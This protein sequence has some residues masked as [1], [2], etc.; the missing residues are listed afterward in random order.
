M[1]KKMITSLTATVLVGFAAVPAHAQAPADL[2]YRVGPCATNATVSDGNILGD[3][4]GVSVE[5]ACPN[6]G[7]D[8]APARGPAMS[9]DE[10]SEVIW[11]SCGRDD[12]PQDPAGA[13]EGAQAAGQAAAASACYLVRMYG[14][15][16]SGG[17]S[18]QVAAARAVANLEITAP[19]IGLTGYGKPESMEL[20]GL[21]TWMW[22]ADP[23]TSTTGPVTSTGTDGGAT[24]TATGTVRK[25]VWDMG[26]GGTVTCSGA[27]AA[28]T[29]YD[30]AYGTDPSPT[31]GY[32]YDRTSAGQPGDAFTVTVTVYWDV[33]WSGEGQS[34]TLATS[35]TR[36]TQLRVGE[37]QVII[38]ERGPGKK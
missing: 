15:S 5:T 7:G 19:E 8:A 27:S 32:R 12:I 10:L 38:D 3:R 16:G 37:V 14:G 22:V 4:R 11:S 17:S 25:T 30:A 33:A 1:I 31:C 23:G 6:G 26:D 18:T 28:G 2:R 20:L 29:P 34:G 24:V 21:P 35:V 36:Q 9:F 13:A